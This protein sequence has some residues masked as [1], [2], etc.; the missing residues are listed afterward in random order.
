MENPHLVFLMETRLKDDEM[1]RI[2]VR[3]GFLSGL[4]VACSGHGRERAG[5]LALI[6]N[7]PINIAITSY[8]L[9]HIMGKGEDDESDEPWFFAGI[10]GFPEE[11]QRRSTWNL[12]RDIAT[13]VS[14][15][16]ICFGD[17]NDTLSLDEKKGGNSR[18][19]EQLNVGRRA[20]EECGLQD[21]GFMGYL[22]TLSNGRQGEEQIQCRLDR[23]F[24][25]EGF[26]S[27]FSPIKVTHLPRF[28][29]DHSPILI[30]LEAHSHS[31]RKK[32]THLF[33][34]EEC[35]VKDNRC[36]DLV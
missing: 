23:A 29:S 12:I 20:V 33:R 34:F 13:Q 22:F 6:W 14:E 8:S 21:L 26:I 3:C 17:I 27:R 24:A 5:G 36:E 32:R 11:N 25:R 7:G 19:F 2:R 28:S 4:S 35:W 31:Y 1:E 30:C 9:N 18:S 10:Y 16:W 15:R